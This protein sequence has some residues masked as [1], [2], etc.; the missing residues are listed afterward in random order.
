[1]KVVIAPDSFKESLPASVAADRIEAGFREVFPTA[2]YV[3]L[4]IADGGEGTV[5]AMVAATEGRLVALRVRGPLGEETEAFYGITGDGK[6]AVIEMA[7][8]SGLALVPLESRN[9][10]KTTSFGTGELI[11]HALDAG[12][13]EFIIGIGGSATNDAGAGMLQA[14]GARFL[15]QHDREIPSGGGGLALLERID[16]SR[17]DPR[18]RD[19]RFLV[20]CDVDNP[21]IG[22]KG[23][24]TVFGPQ[25]GADPEMV[26]ELDANLGRFAERVAA[27]LGKQV[28]EAPGGGAAGGMGAALLAFLDAE[29]RP[30][31]QI[32]MEAVGLEQALAGADLVITGEGKIDA[33]SIHG[34]APLGV[35]RAASRQGIPAVGIAGTLGP[36]WEQL[37]AYGMTALFSMVPGP[38]TLSEALA[39]A[40]ENLQSTA[41]NVAAVIKFAKDL[42]MQIS[43]ELS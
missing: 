6:T 7:V 42:K 22:P 32:I 31:I 4:P 13:R 10:L 27:D 20:A 16:C 35:A 5:E 33:Q 18:L 37:Q 21:L 25:K 19:S 8:A 28:A 30:G 9:P 26:K 2:D 39:A 34:K 40:E 29:L 36:G 41:R 15:D 1:M 24:S 23:A 38:C 11:L 14:M 12:L 17:L 43:G 3:K